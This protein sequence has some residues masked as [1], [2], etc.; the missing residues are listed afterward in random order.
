[1]I[2]PMRRYCMEMGTMKTYG[3]TIGAAEDGER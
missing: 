2:V 3:T 1:M